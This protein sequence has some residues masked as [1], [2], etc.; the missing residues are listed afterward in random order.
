[1]I[2]TS[3][4]LLHHCDCHHKQKYANWANI[5]GNTNKA[6][7]WSDINFFTVKVADVFGS[8]MEYGNLHFLTGCSM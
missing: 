7:L 5:I 3:S 4:G 6:N 1:M 8:Q 2:S